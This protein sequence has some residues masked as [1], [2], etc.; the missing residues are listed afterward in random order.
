MG[1]KGVEPLTFRTSSERSTAE[2]AALIATNFIKNFRKEKGHGLPW[3]SELSAPRVFLS[4]VNV[5][6]RFW[7]EPDLSTLS[8]WNTI[9]TDVSRISQDGS[10]QKRFTGLVRPA[11]SA[12]ADNLWLS[13]HNAPST[14]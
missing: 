6:E 10:E 7:C 11:L 9:L 12:L 14:V 1:D 2:L 13:H 5:K 3:P 4:A 8:F